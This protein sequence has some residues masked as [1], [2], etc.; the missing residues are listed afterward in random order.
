MSNRAT[1][2]AVSL[3]K[4][5][6]LMKID[7]ENRSQTSNYPNRVTRVIDRDLI[8]HNFDLLRARVW[9]R[10]IWPG[11]MQRVQEIVMITMALMLGSIAG[12][13]LLR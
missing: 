1:L 7:Q 6:S 3:V 8:D 10:S 5:E 9:K 13:L 12:W 11:R 4:I 2:L